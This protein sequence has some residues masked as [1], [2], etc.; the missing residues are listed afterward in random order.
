MKRRYIA[1]LLVLS[2][3]LTG[4]TIPT[5]QCF[6]T[7]VTEMEEI[8]TEDIAEVEEGEEMV[9]LTETEVSSESAE[10][11]EYEGFIENVEILEDTSKESELTEG[12]EEQEMVETKEIAKPVEGEVSEISEADNNTEEVVNIPDKVLYSIIASECDN[13][14]DGIITK[15]EMETVTRIWSYKDGISDLTG[16][17]YAVNLYELNL[18]GDNTI[19]NIESLAGLEKLDYV[20]LDNNQISDISPLAN[21]VNLKN[22][23]LS[24]NQ[25]SDISV[26]SNLKNLRSINLSDNP[27]SDINSLLGLENLYGLYLD[28]NSIK[29]ISMLA[30]LK[31]LSYISLAGNQIS[32]ISILS[33]FEYLYELDLAN[34]QISDI[35]ALLGLNNL[36][37][38]NLSNNQISDISV[39]GNL[40]NLGDIDLTNN[41]ITQI[42]SFKSCFGMEELLLKGNPLQNIANAKQLLDVEIEG[43][44][45]ITASPEYVTPE[46][47][48]DNFFDTSERK[49]YVGNQMQLELEKTYLRTGEKVKI[50]YKSGNTDL[51]SIDSEGWMSAKKSGTVNVTATCGTMQKTFKVTILEQEEV[52]K[53]SSEKLP[54]IITSSYEDT[55][56]ILDTKDLLWSVNTNKHIEK[57]ELVGSNV[58]DYYIAEVVYSKDRLSWWNNYVVLN[59]E[60]TLLEYNKLDENAGYNKNI[61]AEDVRTIARSGYYECYLTENDDLYYLETVITG[62]RNVLIAKNVK[63][64]NMESYPKKVFTNDG[65]VL[66]IDNIYDIDNSTV[67][68]SN[69][70]T[71]CVFSATDDGFLILNG[72]TAIYYNEN[73]EKQAEL[74]D[75][76]EIGVQNREDFP[77]FVVKNDGTT[78]EYQN[79]TWVTYGKDSM[80]LPI[81]QEFSVYPDTYILDAENTL[82]CENE[83]VEE[84]V[85][86][87]N[88][89]VY[90]S[91]GNL[92][93]FKEHKVVLTDVKE[94]CIAEPYYYNRVYYLTNDGTV[95]ELI[96]SDRKNQVLNSVVDIIT[97]ESSVYMVRQD[98]SVWKYGNYGDNIGVAYMVQSGDSVVMGDISGDGEIKINDML[99]ILH[100]ISG[101]QTLNES[102]QLAADIDKDGKVTVR[103]MLRIMHYISGASSTL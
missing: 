13:N 86:Y 3:S 56:A 83:K 51:L 70:G 71:E 54:S 1:A 28:G 95:W 6:S 60:N 43:T 30:N 89:T 67:V 42:P 78:A 52:V 8:V 82:W 92:Y 88:Q 57:T 91:N 32:D 77:F 55:A 7:E 5:E 31:R 10:H 12:T 18:R 63:N 29:D 45:R 39:L 58:K 94:Y 33:E 24:N 74:E 76:V 96:D 79:G 41:Q 90:L 50:T 47:Q 25:I 93:T 23:S 20:D 69:L 46:M 98:G 99:T 16:L 44:I 66:L 100:G 17:E 61:L 103:D 35:S 15:A 72:N 64:Y 2:M 53:E 27:I 84:N 19:T 49:M 26:L 73:G 80:K 40:E 68:Y 48:F 4:I 22:L 102:Q 11:A 38:L 85:T 101:S 36:E 14:E 81:K 21:L 75:V 62:K 97:T 87:I 34:N 59:K 65:D 9:E 37:Y